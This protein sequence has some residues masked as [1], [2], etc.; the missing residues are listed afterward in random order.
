MKK[1]ACRLHM[2]FLIEASRK[3]NRTDL[4]NQKDFADLIV[5]IT[6]TDLTEPAKLCGA[7]YARGV[8]PIVKSSSG[9][10]VNRLKFLREL[11]NVQKPFPRSERQGTPN[12]EKAL[13]YALGLLKIQKQKNRQKAGKI[14]LFTKSKNFAL[15]RWPVRKQLRVLRKNGGGVCAVA[16]KKNVVRPLE[17]VTKDAGRVT[18]ING[19]FDIAEIVVATIADVCDTPCH[20]NKN[21][22]MDDI[23]PNEN[24]NNDDP[25]P[26]SSPD[27]TPFAPALSSDISASDIMSESPFPDSSMIEEPGNGGFE[28]APAA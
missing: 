6:T 3:V 9:F 16:L 2:C 20:Q 15:P 28:V 13:K 22:K 23:C 14:I 17:R 26:S 7:T 21:G 19:F 11:R 4:Q 5:A 12:V 24:E 18:D 1:R 10:R 25:E 8:Y 27:V